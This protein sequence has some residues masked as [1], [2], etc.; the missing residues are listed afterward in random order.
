M[1][2][3]L[4]DRFSQ[5]H[6][7]DR[8]KQDFDCSIVWREAE[9]NGERSIN[10]DEQAEQSEGDA[11][12]MNHCGQCRSILSDNGSNRRN[13]LCGKCHRREQNRHAYEKR[14]AKS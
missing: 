5:V 12:A 3:G 14:K 1:D 10:H 2:G 9:S 13:G 8:I 4:Y 7:F 11:A 6:R